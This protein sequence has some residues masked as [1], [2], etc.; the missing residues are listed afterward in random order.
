M[1]RQDNP[2]K[3]SPKEIFG[4]AIFDFGNHAF[5]AV[6]LSVLVGQYL[7]GLAQQSVG[8]N[9]AV[10]TIAGY[11][12]V[13]AKSLFSYSVGLSVFLQIFFLPVLGAIADYTHLKKTF[14]GFFCLVGSVSCASLFFIKDEHFLAGAF[15]FIFS[16]LSAGASTVFLN[17]YLSDITTEDRRDK[18]SSWGFAAGYIGSFTTLVCSLLFLSYSEKFGI[19]TGMAAR[20]CLLFSGVWWG[21]F[22]LL[23]YQFLKRR[24]P[25]RSAPVE[26]HYIVAGF[27]ELKE[28]L[29][30]LFALKHTLHFLVAYLLYNDGIQTVITMS[31]L[32]F[33]QEL[34][35]ARGLE[36]DRTVLFIAFIIAQIV[37]FIGA[38]S[39]ERIAHFTNTKSAIL[40]SLAIWSAIVIYAYAFLTTIT[41]AYF[42]SAAVGFVMGGSQALSRS[43]FSQMIP[44]GRES[45]FFGIYAI[46]DRGTSW[47]GPFI[48]GLVAQLT[49]S[50]RPAIL[51]LI[52]FFIV[53]SIILSTVNV[54]KAIHEAGNLTPDEAAPA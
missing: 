6:V 33:A 32:F 15:L 48:F 41:E 40:L 14:L 10:I 28:T 49:D 50:Y 54:A 25:S 43:L 42:L 23:G 22:S 11:E 46:S 24:L 52:V 53:G 35:A 8:E 19:S 26:Q 13:T 1:D 18:V 36:T 39:F 51:A 7:T 38:L 20:I 12:L 2:T 31:G 9:G 3:N 5:F 30:E 29:K 4:W 27:S 44:E 47:I 34:F 45:A 21:G 16:N 37:A 17:S